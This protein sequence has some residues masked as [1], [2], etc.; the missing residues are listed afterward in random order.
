MLQHG[1]RHVLFPSLWHS[2]LPFYS[3]LQVHQSYSY[4][5][6]IVL[7]AASANSPVSG[8]GGSGIFL[9]R[10]GAAAIHLPPESTQQ[11]LM[12][13]NRITNAHRKFTKSHPQAINFV[14]DSKTHRYIF[15]AHY[16]QRGEAIQ[17]QTIGWTFY[18]ANSSIIHGDIA[19]Q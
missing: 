4:A 2:S 15:N 8:H 5:N 12:N 14:Q 19:K 7:L 17:S 11:V 3:S 1:I 16:G 10:N 6:N 18:L 9:G 13:L